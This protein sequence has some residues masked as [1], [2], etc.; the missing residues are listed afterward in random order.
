[1][2][3][4]PNISLEFDKEHYENIFLGVKTGNT[5]INEFL[6]PP[7]EVSSP[8]GTFDFEGTLSQEHLRV[9]IP[10]EIRGQSRIEKIQYSQSYATG[11]STIAHSIGMDID[12]ATAWKMA[13]HSVQVASQSSATSTSSDPRYLAGRNAA[14]EKFTR[15]IKLNRLTVAERAACVLACTAGSYAGANKVTLSG[16]DQWSNPNSDVIGLVEDMKKAVWVSCGSDANRM[17]ISKNTFWMLQKHPQLMALKK[18]ALN[19]AGSMD[20]RLTVAELSAI[21]GLDVR[22][23]D[24]QYE[25]ARAMATSSKAQCWGNFAWVG[26]VNPSPSRDVVEYSFGYNFW[27]NVEGGNGKVSMR[28]TDPDEHSHAGMTQTLY[29][30]EEYDQMLLSATAGYL[31]TSPIA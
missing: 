28:L 10:T 5:Y 20:F 29:A 31:V 6:F 22:V 12:S 8:T 2:S 9:D 1:M 15:M 19:G 25:T 7:I 26:Y 17:V 30:D 16:T 27:R 21:F 3:S 14:A 23:A 11:W 13:P 4:A 24:A 18:I